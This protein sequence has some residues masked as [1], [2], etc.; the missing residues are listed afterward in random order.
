M[1]NINSHINFKGNA[2][3]VFNL[4]KSIFGGEFIK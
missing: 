1:V 3:E 4:Y 2:E